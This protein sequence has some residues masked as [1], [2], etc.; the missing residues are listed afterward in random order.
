MEKLWR[1]DL[2]TYRDVTFLLTV[3]IIY[4][5]GVKLAHPM[6]SNKITECSGKIKS[7]YLRR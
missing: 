1:N 5:L 3:I 6:I 2:K 4:K 7:Y